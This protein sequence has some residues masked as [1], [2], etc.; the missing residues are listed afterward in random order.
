MPQRRTLDF[1]TFEAMLADIEK[2]ESGGYD[3]AGSWSLGQVCDHLAIVARLSLDPGMKPMPW[4]VRKLLSR[5]VLRRFMRTRRMPAGLRAPKKLLPGD[6]LAD[7]EGV[8][9]WREVVEQLVSSPRPTYFNPAFGPMS[10]E[11]FDQLQL[12]HA[13]HHL[14]FLLPR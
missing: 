10:R 11:V 1:T 3:R 6:S 12:L 13:A 7:A 5:F 14:S 9:R 2:L 8:R 4:V